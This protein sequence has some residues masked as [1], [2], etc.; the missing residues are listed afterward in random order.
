[1]LRET[2]RT[3]AAAENAPALR[4]LGVGPLAGVLR[5][6]RHRNFRLFFFGQLVS[7]IGTWMQTVAQSW[8]IYRLTG[9]SLLLGTVGFASQFPIFVLSP[10]GG[11]VA[12][13]FRRHRVVLATQTAMMLQ[14]FV[15]ALLTLTGRIRIWEI[16]VLATLQGVASAF[17]IPGRQAFLVEMVGREDLMNAIALNS[18]MFNAARIVGPAVAGLVVAAIGEGWCFF[19]NGV[20]FL[21]VI[22]GLLMMRLER[23]SPT[24]AP[25]SPWKAVREG[26]EFARN[27][28]PIRALL[29]LIGLVSLVAM[30]YTVL[31]PIFADRILGGGPG[32]LGLLMSATGL[33]ALGGALLLAARQEVRGLGR[34]VAVSAASFGMSLILF[35]ASRS[36]WLSFALL[37]P[38][39]FAMMVETASTNTLLQTMT[40]DRLR[41]RIMAL[42]SM[43]F[44]GLGPFGALLAGALADRIGAPWTVAAGG[45]ACIAGAA[46]FAGRLPSMRQQA[47][48]LLLAQAM[49]GGEPAEELNVPRQPI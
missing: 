23:T 1:M 17:D 38:C 25:G 47:V 13:H 40:P 29:L 35:A 3:L 32:G 16:M 6:L 43:M 8:L 33:G 31:M 15:F 49:A 10:L 26:F 21:A 36:F 20:S 22:A 12:D 41:G 42:Y 2:T 34:W 48:E 46:V 45:L 9:S 39:G 7:L 28:A 14:A 24:E 27:N 5:S 30:P 18:S 37:V 44:M 19:A 11:I 4:R